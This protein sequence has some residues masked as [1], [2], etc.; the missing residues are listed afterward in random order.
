M[1]FS[2][3]FCTPGLADKIGLHALAR[4]TRAAHWSYRGTAARPRCRRNWNLRILLVPQFTLAADTAK[5][6]RPSLGRAA[7]PEHGREL[8]EALV[9]ATRARWKTVA[10][11]Q[12]GT[13]MDV[14]LV[15][16][17]P[18]TFWIEAK[19]VAET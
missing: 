2:V 14:S 4:A 10:T 16:R 7:D 18:V 19:P 11:G 13:N 9:G 8:F 15:N 17:G 12:F 5:G 6:N 1:L 3:G